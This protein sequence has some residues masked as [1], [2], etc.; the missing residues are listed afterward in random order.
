MSLLRA[1]LAAAV[2]ATSLAAMQA[3][4]AADLIFMSTQLRPIEEAQKVRSAILKGGPAT[5]YVVDEPG[6]F[7]VRARAEQQ[8]GK[9]TASLYG[10]G[11]GEMAPLVDVLQ[12]LDDVAAALK[13]RG[14]PQ[15]LLDSGKF[16]TDHVL[17]IPWMQAS[18]VLVVNKQALP[19]LPAGADVNALTYDQLLAWGKAIQ[20]KT[21]KR[22]LGFPAGPKGLFARF[23]EGSLLPAY[24]GS[25]VTAFRSPEAQKAWGDL[26]ALWAYVNPDSTRY[27]FMQEPLQAGDVWIAWDHVARVREA[28]TAAPDDYVV[29]PSPAGPKGRGAM[30]V[31]AGLSIPKNAPDRAGA[32]SLI[33]H[34]TKPATQIVTASEVGFFPV[35]KADLPAD[36]SPGIKLIAGGLG[37]TMASKDLITVLL[38]VGLGAKGG[39]FNKVYVDTFARIVLN[40]E[41][42]AKVLDEQAAALRTIMEDTK[43]PCWAPD[44]PSSGPCP[45]K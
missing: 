36:L 18:Y 2:M 4:R 17:M 7:T 8:A 35:V 16:G 22:V 1:G 45:V 28:L 42:V 39:E 32:V 15:G 34:L 25:T 14:F 24:T 13:D 29:V 23:L 37:K 9:V 12:P 40:K 38:P 11:H 33:D 3:A 26:T 5:T 19:F 44:A 30:V 21:G 43:A 20:E 10:A 41:P 27:D 6:P 31:L